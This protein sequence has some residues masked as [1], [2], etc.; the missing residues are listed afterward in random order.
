MIGTM[1]GEQKDVFF[2]LIRFHVSKVQASP[3]F[4][5]KGKQDKW[6][7]NIP[8]K[9]KSMIDASYCLRS[10]INTLS[11]GFQWCDCLIQQTSIRKEIYINGK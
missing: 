11:T 4:T 7:L 8:N 2:L 1:E 9:P 3:F 5:A 10:A 6:I